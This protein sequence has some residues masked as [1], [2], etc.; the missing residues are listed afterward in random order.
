MG[1][2]TTAD[3][4]LRALLELLGEVDEDRDFDPG[5][6]FTAGAVVLRR[7]DG[8]QVPATFGTL[9]QLAQLR[10]RGHAA[11]IGPGVFRITAAGRQ[12]LR[13]AG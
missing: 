6:R 12:A 2:A 11:E 7:R 8:G 9:D 13:A 5:V 1:K 3:D 10:G 4:E